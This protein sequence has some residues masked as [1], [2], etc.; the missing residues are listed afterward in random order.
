[1]R[2]YIIIGMFLMGGM[3]SFIATAISICAL[4]VVKYIRRIKELETTLR[5]V[6]DVFYENVI[7]ENPSATFIKGQTGACYIPLI[8]FKKIEKEVEIVLGS[9][10]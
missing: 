3:L 10:E 8:D 7:R 6:G 1:M 9:K 4:F 5:D 2:Q